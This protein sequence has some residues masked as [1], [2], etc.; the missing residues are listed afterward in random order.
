MWPKELENGLFRVG[1]M[2]PLESNEAR[3][4]QLELLGTL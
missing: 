3:F 1:A 4:A 2:G